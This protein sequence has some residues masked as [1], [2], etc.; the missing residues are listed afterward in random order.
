MTCRT[1]SC[2]ARSIGSSTATCS[3]SARPAPC[4]SSLASPITSL[5]SGI[6]F[7]YFRR[8]FNIR[9]YD[10][11]ISFMPGGGVL[12]VSA[13]GSSR[14]QTWWRI[15]TD[16]LGLGQNALGELVADALR[17]AMQMGHV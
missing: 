4:S 5:R 13:D 16:K 2:R 8:V 3:P 6:E 17:C 7:F 14:L 12:T 9:S 15:K 1:P 11:G 10:R